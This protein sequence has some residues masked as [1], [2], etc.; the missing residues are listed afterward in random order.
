MSELNSSL[1][2]FF[3]HT[4]KILVIILYFIHTDHNSY[5]KIHVQDYFISIIQKMQ[6][7]Y[8]RTNSLRPR[9]LQPTRLLCS[10]NSPGQNTGVSC[11]SLLQGIFPTQGSNPGLPHCRQILHQ[12]SHKG[13]PRILEWV[14]YP[15]SSGSSSP[16]D[17]TWVSC[18]AGRFFTVWAT[19]DTLLMGKQ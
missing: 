10:W 8:L 4:H 5:W 9:G 12:L 17:Q 1:S 3:P 2:H 19:R 16:R 15:F 18:I 7:S 11:P 13:S 6:N 14:A